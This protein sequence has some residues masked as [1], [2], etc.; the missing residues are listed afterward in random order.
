MVS[1][2]LAGTSPGQRRGKGGCRGGATDLPQLDTEMFNKARPRY[3]F[4]QGLGGELIYQPVL[5]AQ[6]ID[7]RELLVVIRHERMVERHRL[8][9]D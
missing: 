2:M 5:D 8:G 4:K 9:P 6:A 1:M 7:A 3:Q